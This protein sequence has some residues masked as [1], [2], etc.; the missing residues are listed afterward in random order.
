[1]KFTSLRQAAPP[2]DLWGVVVLMFVLSYVIHLSAQEPETVTAIVP[3]LSVDAGHV[4]YL[5]PNLTFDA[6]YNTRRAK[7]VNIRAGYVTYIAPALI[8]HPE[9]AWIDE[10]REIRGR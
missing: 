5:A 8:L 6:E 4:T 9:Q 1:M 2:R 7:P 3:V 10:Q